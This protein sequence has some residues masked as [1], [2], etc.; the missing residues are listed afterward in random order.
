MIAEALAS[1]GAN[2]RQYVKRIEGDLRKVERESI[3]DYVRESENLA[4]LHMKIRSCD[5][6][7]G[8]MQDLLGTF[9]G[10]LGKVSAEIKTLQ[11]R[12]GKLSVKAKNRKLVDG[13]LSRFVDGAGVPPALI[14]TITEADV[15]DNYMEYLLM[16]RRKC[17]FIE[18]S[19]A[20]NAASAQELKP[21]LE[22]LRLKAAD[23]IRTFLLT[24]I[25][26]LA[27][28]KTNFQIL[29][30][31]VL[32]KF[33]HLAQFLKEH[34]PT[35]YAE[36]QDQYIQTMS[37]IYLTHFRAHVRHMARSQAEVMSASDTIVQADDV[38][39]SAQSSSFSNLWSSPSLSVGGMMSAMGGMVGSPAHAGTP[40]GVGGEKPKEAVFILGSRI[41]LLSEDGGTVLMQ[42]TADQKRRL[43]VSFKGALALLVSTAAS[44]QGFIRDFFGSTQMLSHI[45]KPSVHAIA[46]HLKTQVEGCFD[47]LSLLLMIR[48]AQDVGASL[49]ERQLA[50]LQRFM[51]MLAM[52]LWPRFKALLDHQ[53]DSV[54]SAPAPA[55][56][57]NGSEKFPHYVTRRYGE[58]SAS[59]VLLTNSA[60]A[61][62]LAHSLNFMRSEL[63]ALLQRMAASL[64]PRR[65]QLVFL[66]NQL[67]AI[68]GIYA[69]R[70]L[71][72]E[73]GAA[74][75][76][77]LD[78]E[79]NAF[80]EA[81]LLERYGPLVAF[82]LE[83]EEAAEKA[84][85]D[86]QPQPTVQVAKVRPL[87]EGFAA[88]WKQGIDQI[89]VNVMGNFHNMKNGMEILKRTLTQ[90]LLYYTRF[91]D[92][93]KRYCNESSTLSRD[94]VNIPSIIA[95]IKKYSRTF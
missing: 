76:Q 3:A 74:W 18:T 82:V 43:E 68:I 66:I 59:I 80:V 70:G 78:S 36:V 45:F 7:L 38:G 28:P 56:L 88:S 84:R 50:D 51:D 83:V 75:Q 85:H 41:K 89:N 87:V 13:K 95:E 22:K 40:T 20:G 69:E 25:F 42:S 23:G 35:V 17:T 39:Q 53:M 77:K 48:S 92:L 29:Q 49:A 52:L 21:V 90:L 47:P 24:K 94:M 37:D 19:E 93:I 91:L 62:M 44:E 55:L 4:Q 1:E 79:V 54:R 46:E 67:D 64:S 65:R 2:L 5:E 14:E 57:S 26:S 61:E 72:A 27:R 11:E 8:N 86:N 31:S 73:A 81:E 33:K 15:N 9:Q 10:N 12:A 32:L 16:L 34:A 6:V 63:D 71:G 60:S 58:L 30:Q